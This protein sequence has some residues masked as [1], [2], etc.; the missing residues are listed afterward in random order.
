MAYPWFFLTP[1]NGNNRNS[2]NKP[3]QFFLHAQACPTLCNPMNI[4]YQAPLSM[5]FPRQEHWNGLPFPSP[6]DLPDPGIKPVPPASPE[7]AGGFFTTWATWEAH[8]RCQKKNFII[9]TATIYGLC[10]KHITGRGLSLLWLL[11]MSNSWRAKRYLI[12]EIVTSYHIL[13]ERCSDILLVESHMK[14]TDSAEKQ[15]LQLNT[16]LRPNIKAFP[17]LKKKKKRQ[18]NREN[19]RPFISP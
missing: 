8:V 19:L 14:E 3:C 15:S 4:A 10:L 2:H 18:K 1:L 7:L 6:G 5:G 12:V 11:K 17:F 9:P 13:G 16:A